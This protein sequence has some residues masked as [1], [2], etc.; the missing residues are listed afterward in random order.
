[1]KRTGAQSWW[2]D[3]AAWVSNAGWQGG[4]AAFGREQSTLWGKLST[5]FQPVSFLSLV[6]FSLSSSYFIWGLDLVCSALSSS[7]LNT[8]TLFSS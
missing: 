3:C 5:D 1:M 4:R 7:V 2:K 8:V 6:L